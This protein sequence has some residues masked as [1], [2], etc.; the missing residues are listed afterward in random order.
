MKAYLDMCAIQRPLDTPSQVRLVLE[1][2]AVLGLLS[3]CQAG[4]LELV[5]SDAL[6]FENEQNPSPIRREY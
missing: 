1:A 3:L 5:L 4:V 2:E 6:V